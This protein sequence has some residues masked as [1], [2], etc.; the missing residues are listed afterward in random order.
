MANERAAIPV[1]YALLRTHGTRIADAT[2]TSSPRG[3]ESPRSFKKLTGWFELPRD[4]DVTTSR[5]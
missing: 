3:A 1:L 2:Y 4:E 5:E